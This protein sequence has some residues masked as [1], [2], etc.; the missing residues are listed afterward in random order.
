MQ[1]LVYVSSAS[2]LMK[3]DELKEILKISRTRN[4]SD[5]LTGMLLYKDG[6]FMQMLEGEEEAVT[7][8][9]NR[10]NDDSRHNGLI[11]ICKETAESRIFD[12]WS[13][14]F[15]TVNDTDLKNIPGYVGLRNGDFT[16]PSIIDNHHFAMT[17]LKTFYE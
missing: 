10:I 3:E 9:F 2:H 13:M 8:T 14:G 16:D 7:K 11:V 6:S 17:I 5:G 15:R 4:L 12:G 1:Y